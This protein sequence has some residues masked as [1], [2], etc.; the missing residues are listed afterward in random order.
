MKQHGYPL[1]EASP[2][3]LRLGWSVATLPAKLGLALLFNLKRMRN[4]R[5]TIKRRMA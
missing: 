5:E 2:N 4:I 1:A 3:P